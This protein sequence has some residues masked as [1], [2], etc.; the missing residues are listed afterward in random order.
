[1]NLERQVVIGSGHEGREFR[2]PI[3][4]VPKSEKLKQMILL[5]IHFKWKPVNSVLGLVI[6][7][8]YMA[9]IGIKDRYFM[10]PT[11]KEHHKILIS[12]WRD[13]LYQFT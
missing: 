6:H 5:Y 7:N 10:V 1:M 9:K 11:Q 12:Y 13:K 2:C 3:F 4:F 8:C